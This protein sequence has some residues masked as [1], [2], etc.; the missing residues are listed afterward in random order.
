[1]RSIDETMGSDDVFMEESFDAEFLDESFMRDVPTGEN[2]L[3]TGVYR[4]DVRS[5]TLKQD[6][7]H[8]VTPPHQLPAAPAYQHR[9][10]PDPQPVVNTAAASVISGA[11]P[12]D[13]E[14]AA[15]RQ[16]AMKAAMMA[17]GEPSLDHSI[18]DPVAGGSSGETLPDARKP[19]GGIAN[20]QAVC[21]L[22]DLR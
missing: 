9:H 14:G 11:K 4:A 17:A 6:L 7:P 12:Y 15:R 22:T 19:I 8:A 2:M 20:P 10:R 21:Q 18:E 3:V 13:P 5:S 16:A 1:M